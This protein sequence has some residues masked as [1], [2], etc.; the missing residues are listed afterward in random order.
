MTLGVKLLTINRGD[1]DVQIY[2]QSFNRWDWVSH[3]G[4]VRWLAS[5]TGCNSY[6]YRNVDRVNYDRR[7]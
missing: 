1:L 5:C 4:G 2:I 7:N 3:C 6:I